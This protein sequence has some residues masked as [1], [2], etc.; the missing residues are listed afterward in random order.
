MGCGSS[1]PSSSLELIADAA[2][3]SASASTPPNQPQ[4]QSSIQSPTQS[5]PVESAPQEDAA[6]D[7]PPVKESPDDGNTSAPEPIG[8]DPAG[9][10]ELTSEPP[11]TD[12]TVHAHTPAQTEPP[13][14]GEKGQVKEEG[15]SDEKAALPPVEAE[16]EVSKKKE[17]DED[18][19]DDATPPSSSSSPPAEV[20]T[21]VAPAGVDEVAASSEIPSVESTQAA[22][23]LQASESV[24]A[25]QKEE[26]IVSETK[27]EAASKPAS[28]EAPSS[29]T[30]SS[31]AL[32]PN[33]VEAPVAAAP[34]EKSD[35]VE[36]SSPVAELPKP[37]R[38]AKPQAVF[39]LG[40]PGSGKG[41]QCANIV[42]QF[43]WVHLSAGDLLRD[44]RKKNG[45][46]AA[47]IEEYIIQG[48]IVPADLTV[49][50]LKNAMEENVAK[51]KTQF[52]IDGS[53]N[54]Q[55]NCIRTR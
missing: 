19:N 45:P 40:G 46:H 25:P 18:K 15:E 55:T 10:G 37:D 27:A 28:T 17:A 52:L 36:S 2:P 23:P 47:L 33:V 22:E 30:S 6:K 26:E 49:L 24:E 12:V 16:K 14:S 7:A 38:P 1:S 54:L 11:P 13:T 44:E 50:L 43:G 51:D 5:P 29:L 41:T 8:S 20:D 4:S 9:V 53:D 35:T 31:S 39:V 3:A 32:E 21:A 48:K 34:A 42:N